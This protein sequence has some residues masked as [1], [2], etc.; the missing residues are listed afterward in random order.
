MS[1]VRLREIHD[2]QHR[3]DESLQRNH[4]DVEHRPHRAE[5][6]L[7]DCAA[8]TRERVDCEAAAEHGEQQEDDFA[9]IQVAEQ[10]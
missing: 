7:A 2:R 9:R 4:Q 1:F 3:E 8:H 10:S 6:E 5:Q